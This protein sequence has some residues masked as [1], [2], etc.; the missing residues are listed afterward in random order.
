[1]K[2]SFDFFPPNHLKMSKPF[3]THRPHENRQW[4][5]FGSQATAYR[6]LDQKD[7]STIKTETFG[8]T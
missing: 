2:Y 3:L 4:A 5:T 6:P 1:M 7:R 8:E